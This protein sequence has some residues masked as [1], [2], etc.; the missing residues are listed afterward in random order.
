MPT[1]TQAKKVHLA[2][3]EA[4]LASQWACLGG[5]LNKAD[6]RVSFPGGSWIQWVYADQT[7]NRGLRCDLVLV[8]ECD[9][10]DIEYYDAITLPWFSE[11]HSLG[12]ALLSGTPTR[13]R[14]GLL[15][16]RH[17][18]ALDRHPNHHSF[19]ATF[20][21]VPDYVDAA[22][23]EEARTTVLPSLFAREWLCDFDSAEG[24]VY[25]MF[26]ERFHVREPPKDVVWSEFGVGG[27]H[28]YEDPGVL[29]YCAVNGHGRDAT[30]WVLHEVYRQHQV[31][32]WWDQQATNWNKTLDRARWYLDPSRPDLIEAF[33]R[34][35]CQ[36]VRA[37]NAIDEGVSTVANMLSIRTTNDAGRYAKLYVH[38]RCKNLIREFGEYRRKRDPRNKERV[39]DD[40]EDKNN[41]SMD[42]LRYFVHTRFGGPARSVT[43]RGDHEYRTT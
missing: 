5:S 26:D 13:G 43:A 29:L 6:W 22:A 4:E 24:L 15:Y 37:D 25:P 39:L 2:L 23:V 3:L 31:G 36:T 30:V 9:D 17:R 38:P 10:V 28:G 21:D 33:R 19:H 27:D 11:P 12:L 35:G 32:S 18:L 14:Y 8:D 40:I 42:A 20:R 7:A 34:V 41:H 1:L 16:K